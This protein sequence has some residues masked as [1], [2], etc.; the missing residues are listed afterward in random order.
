MR[1]RFDGN[2]GDQSKNEVARHNQGLG[3]RRQAARVVACQV[4]RMMAG[5]FAI[6]LRERGFLPRRAS[7]ARHQI[8]DMLLCG[9]VDG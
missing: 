9:Q 1:S 3:P 6:R 5:V 2:R 7:Q 4:R 8:I